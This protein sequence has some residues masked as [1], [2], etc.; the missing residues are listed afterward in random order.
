MILC[1]TSHTLSS[2]GAGVSISF[3]STLAGVRQTLSNSKRCRWMLRL[4]AKPQ[5][6]C[7]TDYRAWELCRSQIVESRLRGGI[8]RSTKWAAVFDIRRAPHGWNKPRRLQANGTSLSRVRP[9]QRSLKRTWV[10]MQHS[11]KDSEPSQTN[12]KGAVL[13]FS[14]LMQPSVR[15]QSDQ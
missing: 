5:R 7:G 8:T 15:A 14:F 12:L 13:M 9:A 4:A 2:L 1:K 6:S 3:G 10:K 11:R